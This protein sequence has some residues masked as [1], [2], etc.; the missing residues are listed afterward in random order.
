MKTH[1]N[2]FIIHSQAHRQGLR[3]EQREEDL[4]R[5]IIFLQPLQAHDNC[6]FLISHFTI[7]VLGI[8]FVSNCIEMH[9]LI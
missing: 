7:M 5:A 3:S 1:Y 2:A 8:S 4:I 9:L 6:G